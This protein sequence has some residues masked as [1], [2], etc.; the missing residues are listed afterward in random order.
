V[1]RFGYHIVPLGWILLGFALGAIFLCLVVAYPILALT[2]ELSLTDLIQIALA[3]FLAL[4]IPYALEASRERTRYSRDILVEEVQTFMALTRDVNKLLLEC[5]QSGNTG[6]SERMQVRASFINANVKMQAIVQ[7]VEQ[8]C[9]DSS[10]VTTALRESYDGYYSVVTGGSLYGSN[11][12]AD[13]QLWRKQ[14]LPFAELENA[15]IDL[16]RFLRD[17]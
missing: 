2:I 1:R 9:Q 14:V 5:A 6:P 7:R 17:L 16:I 12:K 10:A 4:Y 8:D 3:L 13:W 15:A 11:G